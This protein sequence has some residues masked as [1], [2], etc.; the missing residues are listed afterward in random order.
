[1]PGLL[2]SFVL[3]FDKHKRQKSTN[4]NEE[5]K[6]KYF[7]CSL[8]GYFV[9]EYVE[10]FYNQSQKVLKMSWSLLSSISDFSI[11]EETK[12]TSTAFL[13]NRGVLQLKTFLSKVITLYR[14]RFTK[15]YFI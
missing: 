10:I 14:L 5:A 11:K 4:I 9:G 1:M 8:I 13:T 3:R 12:K 15:N 7:H 6:I 2:L